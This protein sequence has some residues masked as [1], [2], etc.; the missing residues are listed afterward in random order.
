M[1]TVAALRETSVLSVPRRGRAEGTARPGDPAA[2]VIVAG[3]ALLQLGRS[4]GVRTLSER[5][6]RHK[7]AVAGGAVGLGRS[8][9]GLLPKFSRD[10]G[11]LRRFRLVVHFEIAQTSRI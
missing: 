1:A 2:A 6:R 8:W 3:I 7:N 4:G 10:G 9:D 11:L 5:A